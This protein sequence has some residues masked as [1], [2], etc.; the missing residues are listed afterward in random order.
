MT[1][2]TAAALAITSVFLAL[3]AQAM[4]VTWTLVDVTLSDGGT[5]SGS[6]V[7]DAATLEYSD[8]AVNT[9]PG[10]IRPGD[11]YNDDLPRTVPSARTITFWTP[12]SLPRFVMIFG[13]DLTDAGGTVL[14]APGLL[15]SFEYDCSTPDADCFQIIPDSRRFVTGGS[16]TATAP[17]VVVEIN[18]NGVESWD[19]LG[20]PNNTVWNVDLAAM[21]GAP[22][23]T[24]VIVTGGGWDVTIT[25]FGDSWYV[26]AI[27]DIRDS[28]QLFLTPGTD[29]V[30]GNGV[31]RTYAS[32]GIQDFTDLGFNDVV[33]PDGIL[34]L[35]F[36]E[37]FDD[38]PGA[39]DAVWGGIV[40]FEALV[41]LRTD[42]DEDGIDDSLDNCTLVPN[43]PLIPDAGGNS[44]WDTDGDGFG[45]VCDGDF[46][47]D[48]IVN[49]FDLGIF[50]ADFFTS[51]ADSDM[52]GDGFVNVL[53]LGILKS[54]FLGVPGPSAQASCPAP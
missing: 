7:F 14:I 53:D 51:D 47:D 39:V 41:P 50:K 20:S 10:T 46:N 31:P 22:S 32:N 45:N 15:S 54:G 13:E 23:G 28:P 27:M 48:C 49:A 30:A 42:T 26:E 37:S 19:A 24:Q 1:R 25:P 3:S 12:N 40:S 35:E 34:T 6:F 16:V 8:V 2:I 43:G 21:V 11:A 17:P 4:P 33:L 44:Q 36:Y 29:L 52:N 5:A 38:F 18:V 9:T